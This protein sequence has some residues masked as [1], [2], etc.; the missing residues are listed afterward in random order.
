MN[1]RKI[2]NKRGSVKTVRMTITDADGQP[3]DLTGFTITA[4]VTRR[5]STEH[6]R[7]ATITL[8]DQLTLKGKFDATFDETDLSVPAGFYDFEV[9]TING[10]GVPEY[11]PCVEGAPFGKYILEESKA[12]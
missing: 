4:Y 7:N 9:K 12:I 11:F 5:N 6:V 2:V 8:L 10:N 3:V 1:N